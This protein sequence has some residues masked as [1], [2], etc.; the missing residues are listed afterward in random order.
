M[1]RCEAKILLLHMCICVYLYEPFDYWQ[2]TL[3]YHKH[4]QDYRSTNSWAHMLCRTRPSTKKGFIQDYVI[5]ENIF[6]YC[7]ISFMAGLF[8]PKEDVKLLFHV[9][10]NEYYS[11]FAFWIFQTTPF[12]FNF[13][14]QLWLLY[15]LQVRK[16]CNCKLYF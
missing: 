10:E 8:E 1:R 13:W 4:L 2:S 7:L 12:L 11:Y 6:N 5:C 3:F 16:S 14:A 15:N 9:F